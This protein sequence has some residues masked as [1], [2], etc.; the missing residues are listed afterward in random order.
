MLIDLLIV[1]SIITVP[2]ERIRS[3]QKKALAIICIVP[4]LLRAFWSVNW[5]RGCMQLIDRW[6]R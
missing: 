6:N 1:V 5:R 2:D 3:A 4:K